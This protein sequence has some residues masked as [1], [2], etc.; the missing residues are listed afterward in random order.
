MRMV[1]LRRARAVAGLAAVVTLLAMFLVET[2]D[3][4]VTIEPGRI[5]TL[6]ALIAALLG[7]DLA[8]SKLPFTVTFSNEG[9][10]TPE[11]TNE[12]D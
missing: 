5:R 2:L 10:D 12:K 6:V 4:G 8:G 9:G 11:N 1:W 7:V 3:A